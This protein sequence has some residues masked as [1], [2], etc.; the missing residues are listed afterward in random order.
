MEN[1][2]PQMNG[3]GTGPFMDV[4][5]PFHDLPGF[6][7]NGS[8]GAKMED[9]EDMQA[10]LRSGTDEIIQEA[11]DNDDSTPKMEES[12][13]HN[14]SQ[15]MSGG[16]SPEGS[17]ARGTSAQDTYDE[18]GLNDTGAGDG[19]DLGKP[20][21]DK[22]ETPAWT[23]L[24]TKAGKERKRLPLACIACRRKKIRCSGE[25]PACKH[26][27]RS[28]IPCVYKVTTRKAA[29]RTDY[30]AMLDKR[31]KRM[32]ER[33]IRI[34]PKDENECASVVRAQVKP[35]IPGTAQAKPASSKKR[36]AEEAFGT[37]LQAWA[38]SAKGSG[39]E[40]L[41][42]SLAAHEAEETKL[43][44]EG[45][46][47]LPEK[48]IQ[49][50][51]AEVFFDNLYGQA[52][53]VLH[54][55]SYM[56]KL[57]SDT[58]PPVLILAV[59]AVSARFSTHPK[60]NSQPA[61]LRGESWAAEARNI[62]LKR[63][64]WPNITI[65]TCLLLLGLHEFGTCYG[66][67]S[68]A[69][70]GMAIRMAY[71]LQLHRDLEYDPCKPHSRVRLSFV[72]REIRRRTM[73][74]CFLMDRFNSSGTDRPMFIKEETIMVQ[75]PIKEDLFQL[76]I[77]GPTEDMKGDVPFPSAGGDG[78]LSNARENMGVAAFTIRSIAL[79]GRIIIYYFQGGRDRDPASIWADDSEFAG[80][81]IQSE[82]FER[83]L[84]DL[85]QYTPANLSAHETQGLGNQFLFLHITVQQTILLLAHN[86]VHCSVPGPPR[87]AP[88]P[89]FIES[90]AAAATGA[91][92]RIS[93]LLRVAEAY[94]LTA[95]FA[96]YCAFLS[97]TA[98]MPLAFSKD[99]AVASLA[100]RNLATNVRYLTKMKRGWGVFHWTS[101]QLKKH[102]KACAFAAKRGGIAG[103]AN[104][105][106]QY[107]DW[108]DRYPHGVS[109]GDFEEAARPSGE[110]G[111]DAVLEPKIGLRTV[112]EFVHSIPPAAA[113]PAQEGPKQSKRKK[114]TTPQQQQQQQPAPQPQTSQPQSQPQQQISSHPHHQGPLSTH[115]P[116]PHPLH[117]PQ[118]HAALAQ[119][120]Q[121]QM[122]P[123][124]LSHS[125]HLLP[126]SQHHQPQHPQQQQQQHHPQQQQQ[127]AYPHTPSPAFPHNPTPFY[128]SPFPPDIMPNL[129]A[130]LVFSAYNA[131]TA[132]RGG[133]SPSPGAGMWSPVGMEGL[134][135]G[136]STPSQ[137]S[138][139][140]QGQ[141][142]GN[143]GNG[144]MAMGGG[145]GWMAHQQTSA[146]FMPFN[147]APPDVG[148]GAGEEAFLGLGLGL[149]GGNGAG[150]GLE[151]GT[152]G[153]GGFEGG[154][155]GEMGMGGF[156]G[157]GG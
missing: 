82:A 10:S 78:E 157:G 27:L 145:Q 55:P 150:T 16:E 135:P 13:D 44:V 115:R 127:Q 101:E 99:E 106:S 149:G 41:P 25:K 6:D 89:E 57:K 63:Y 113:T 21:E 134:D 26:C 152:G 75:L 8:A 110:S 84:P 112:E 51:L 46:D 138:Q 114:K 33:I 34:I 141:G 5:Y 123:H 130:H 81:R 96:G 97:S 43:L 69:L 18:F 15:D 153:G 68:W 148:G 119:Q 50:H 65:L 47:A 109:Q 7:T 58:L 83:S 94:P 120:Q 122:S 66:G 140:V 98:Q 73:W 102:F 139:G 88:P 132:Q 147:M 111:E 142:G 95:P 128:P 22:N 103:E 137:Q 154:M 156:E 42:A 31:L 79:W 136:M 24:K 48:E 86:A 70:G 56:R 126:H 144:G 53:H 133:P 9:D 105:V 14:G 62:V 107:G 23:E 17:R 117:I 1:G 100:K 91:A 125:P 155:M 87:P 93:A 45:A 104:V 121:Q 61:F 38:T 4:T 85:L 72:D 124:A 37:E 40:V 30:M 92:Q 19:T 71:A 151:G 76:D 2:Q 129:D 59:C 146:W 90:T 80:L 118:Q 77:E 52:Y 131:P 143:G 64:E 20:K 32:E 11:R 39:S 116:Q 28:R 54:K 74:A 108:F 12:A 36:P 35:A 67:R 29:P 60:I 49:E 3:M